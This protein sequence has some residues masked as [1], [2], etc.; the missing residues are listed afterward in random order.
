MIFDVEKI[1]ARKKS[2]L[3][4]SNFTSRTTLFHILLNFTSFR[5]RVERPLV[6]YTF[7][8]KAGCLTKSLMEMPEEGSYIHS[9]GVAKCMWYSGKR[10][11]SG[12]YNL[13]GSKLNLCFNTHGVL[14]F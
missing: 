14:L 2:S 3:L 8:K 10:L 12:G 7:T 6:E 11:W 1:F 9:R 13:S 5:V 4:T